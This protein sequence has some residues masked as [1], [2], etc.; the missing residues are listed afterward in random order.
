VPL[1]CVEL[2]MGM[3]AALKLSVPN[4]LPPEELSARGMFKLGLVPWGYAVRRTS[5]T[6][7]HA[8]GN[9]SATYLQPARCRALVAA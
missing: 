5:V 1:W 8:T 9:A 7:T 2:G 6:V 4:P 3:L